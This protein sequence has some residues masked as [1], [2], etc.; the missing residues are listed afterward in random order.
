MKGKKFVIVGAGISG[1]VT[2]FYLKRKIEQE[3][4]NDSIL[5]LEQDSRVGGHIQSIKDQ[6]F[7]FDGGPR[8]FLAEG[9]RTL[10]L[11]KELGI[12][13]K[14][15]TSR[16]ESRIRYIWR[17]NTLNPLP[18]KPTDIFTSKIIRF[19]EI[20]TVLGEYFKKSS[21][22]SDDESVADFFTRRFSAEILDNFA[23]LLITGV[24]AGDP[25]KLSAKSIFPKL[26]ELEGQYGSIL[27]GFIKSKKQKPENHFDT[28][29]MSIKKT[30]L[31]SFNEGMETIVTALKENL[32]QI[33][34]TKV[35]I[36]NIAFQENNSSTI[37]YEHNGS[38]IKTDFDKII[39]ATPAYLTAEILKS[40][41]PQ[42]AKL[43]NEIEYAH[44]HVV[45]LGYHK[46][47]HQYKGFGFL[48]PR[49]EKLKMLGCIWNEMVF[50]SLAPEGEVNITAMYGGACHPEMKDWDNA[51]LIYEVRKELELT[52]KIKEEPDAIEIFKYQKGIPQYNI[53]YQK[54]I[55]NIFEILKKNPNIFLTGSYINGVGINDCVKNAYNLIREFNLER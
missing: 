32:D 53:G 48:S 6:G 47:V 9:R 31:V 28:D 4:R 15:Q 26:K 11:C 39:F 37:L 18:S 30:K 44:I 19:K 51:K 43:L 5:L 12:W 22:P 17:N 2:A 55:D 29:I 50:P 24:Y 1:L 13:N 23:E 34:K 42:L 35:N 27:K 14:I 40:S 16:D 45:C 46:K 33:I 41:H 52:M 21:A 49:K 10:S 36:K 20:K 7:I 3:N 25:K 8:G 38:Q 54:I